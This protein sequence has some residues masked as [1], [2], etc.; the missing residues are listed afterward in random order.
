MYYDNR[1][2][3]IFKVLGVVVYF[4]LGKYVCI[5]YLCI[6]KEKKL[7]FSHRGFEETASENISGIGI[8]EILL[9]IVSCYGFIQEVTSTL[10]LK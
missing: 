8:T 7:Y 3:P 1:K 6:E 4:F 5:D 2:S 9:N 10:M